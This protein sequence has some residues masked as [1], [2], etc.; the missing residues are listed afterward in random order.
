MKRK[1]V[2]FYASFISFLILLF[3]FALV[4]MTSFCVTPKVAQGPMAAE[5]KSYDFYYNQ[6]R[7]FYLLKEYEKAMESFSQAI[8]IEPSSYRAHNFCGLAYFHL[9]NYRAAEE[10]FLEAIKLNPSFSEAYTNL[11]GLYFASRRF[12]EARGMLDK[13]LELSPN[14]VAAHATLGS[15]LLLLGDIN[16]G[17]QHLAKALDIDPAYLEN[18]PPL[19]IDIPAAQTSMAEIY[20]AYARI[21]A[22]KGNIEKTVEYLN[23]ARQAGFSD[24][25]RIKREKEFELVRDDPRIQAIIR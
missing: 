4:I 5:T 17:V 20:F 8:K 2:S 7:S 18:N 1:D 22:Q 14:S 21:Y 16:Q 25:E 6:G 15:L 9:K 13:A 11:G 10:H 23:K 19:M 12:N 24:W 3:F